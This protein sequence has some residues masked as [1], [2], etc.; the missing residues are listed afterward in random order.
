[1]SKFTIDRKSIRSSLDKLSKRNNCHYLSVPSSPMS[2][3]LKG[4]VLNI[5]KRNIDNLDNFA[6]FTPQNVPRRLV[7]TSMDFSSK[8]EVSV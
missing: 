4:K 7:A 2:T 3:P 5:R 1:M 8:V 6:L